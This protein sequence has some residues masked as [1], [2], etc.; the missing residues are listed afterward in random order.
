MKAMILAAGFG[1]RLKPLTDHLPKAL[2]EYAGKPMLA[3]QIARLKEAGISEGI[4]NVHHHPEKMIE[5]ISN[6][7]FG[8]NIKLSIETGDILGTGG[9]ILNTAEYFS[10]EEYFTVVNVDIDSNFDLK[11]LI[12]FTLEEKP[13]A[14]LAVQKRQTKR[15]LVFNDNMTMTGLQ[16]DDSPPD[17]VYAFNCMHV[18]SGDI[19]KQGL[20]VK[21]TGIFDIYLEMI[22]EGKKILGYDTGDSFFKDLGKIENLKTS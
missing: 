3:H 17:N 14:S 13:F 2:I 19:F 22:K 4:I 8:M 11:K 16:K 10:D 15:G 9:G 1:T 5:Y 7:D 12:D 18:I 20:E 21:F 6:N